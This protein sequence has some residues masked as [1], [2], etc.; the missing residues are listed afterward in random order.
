LKAEVRREE[1]SDDRLAIALNLLGGD[2]D[3][4]EFESEMTKGLLRVYALKNKLV[5]LNSTNGCGYILTIN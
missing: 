4:K 2:Q 5:R 1:V 3:W